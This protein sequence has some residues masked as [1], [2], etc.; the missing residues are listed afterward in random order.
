MFLKKV[1]IIIDKGCYKKKPPGT[2]LKFFVPFKNRDQNRIFDWYKKNPPGN[3]L[4]RIVHKFIIL[5]TIKKTAVK[6]NIPMMAS[7]FNP[8]NLNFVSGNLLGWKPCDKSYCGSPQIGRLLSWKCP[9]AEI[10]IRWWYNY[11]PLSL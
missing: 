4:D 8:P 9:K 10:L 6:I 3:E 11:H 7:P 5:T 2:F 1:Y